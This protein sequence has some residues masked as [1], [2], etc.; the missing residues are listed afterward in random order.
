MRGVGGHG[1]KFTKNQQKVKNK[2]TQKNKNKIT[3]DA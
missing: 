3:V 2:Q 1:E